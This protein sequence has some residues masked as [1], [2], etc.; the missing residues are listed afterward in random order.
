MS[1][2][3]ETPGTAQ[4]AKPDLSRRT[5]LRRAAAVGL[6]AVPAVGLLEACATGGDSPSDQSTGGT[7]SAKNPLGVDESAP[8]EVVIFAGGYSDKYATDY[9]VPLYKKAFPKATVK[10]SS[11]QDIQGTLQP[12]FSGGTPP[13]VVDNSGTKFMDFGA[14][15]SDN[16]LQDLTDLLNA[17]SVDDASKT[18][19]DT[20]VPGTVE[21]GTYSD[22]NGA[23]P[24]PYVLNYV[25][26]VYGI[27]YNAKL[28]QTRGWTAPTT[29]ADFTALLDK[30]K[31]AG[32]TPYG[33][34]GANASYY[35]Y[36][37]ILTSA[38][39]IAGPDILKN[40]DNLEP[41][42]W[43]NDA[44]KQSATAWAQIGA[45]YSDKAFLG[46][47]HTDVQL[48]QNQ[49]KVAFYPSGDWLP[50]EQAKETPADFQYQLM[51]TPAVTTSD[52]MPANAVRA[53]AGEGFFVPARAANKAGGLEYLRQMLSKAGGKGF[54]ESTKSPTVVVG[55]ADGFDYGPGVTSSQAALKTAG[56]NVFNLFFDSDYAELDKECRVATNE[57]FYNGGTA[58]AWCQRMQKKADAIKA[59]STVTKF[60]R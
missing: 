34:A 20:L 10:E 6:L 19:K 57:L 56:S 29:W 41:G 53:A 45:K 9:H 52:K 14:L 36:L 23:N 33:Y 5:V 8:L 55:A 11:T 43:T 22:K 51:P 42:A 4:T 58:D 38:A 27:W 40:I 39:K 28:F 15:I 32:I 21:V 37:V 30:I 17:A 2:S 7:K 35:Q 13:D 54:T 47:K 44:V 46:L 50:N 59:D 24:K 48:Q 26:T 60:K 3:P 18:V 12:R 16:Q 1:L 25:F 31:A 49:Y